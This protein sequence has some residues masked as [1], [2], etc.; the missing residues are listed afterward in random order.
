MELYL[1]TDAGRTIPLRKVENFEGHGIVIAYMNCVIKKQDC[2]EW[3]SELS[4]K[5]GQRVV[6]LNSCFSKLELLG[7][8]D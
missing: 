4:K 1:K 8:D 6:L 2:E 5:L 7:K 3:E